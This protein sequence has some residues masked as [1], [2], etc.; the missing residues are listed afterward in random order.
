MRGTVLE[1]TSRLIDEALYIVVTPKCA[2][3]YTC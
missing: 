3:C 2:C 1:M